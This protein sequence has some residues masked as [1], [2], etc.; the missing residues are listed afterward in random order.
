MRL[1]A[2]PQLRERLLP[3]FLQA[4][5]VLQRV[6]AIGVRPQGTLVYVGMHRGDGFERL[7]RRF[8]RSIGI[9]ANPE[10]F[11]ALQR[12]YR[13][14][15]Y[16]A[17]YNVAA[18]AEAG[19]ARF[20]ISS[21]DGKSSSLGEF[22]ADWTQRKTGQVRMD[23]SIRVPCVNLYEFLQEQG[24]RHIDYYLSDI[25]GMDLTVLKTLRPLI[26]QRAIG[27]IQCEV[28]KDA[29]GNVYAGLET[30]GQSGFEELLGKHYELAGTGWGQVREG[31][32]DGTP[33]DWWEMDCLWV[34]RTAGALGG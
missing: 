15:P 12:R 33:E 19:H 14:Y 21:N 32:F 17:L 22:R 30:N 20:N 18:A 13:R 7:F 10:L 2:G 27:R 24:I 31:R 1:T 29:Y 9:E 25:Q 28:A 16:V 11:R 3:L 6:R 8:E 34:R 4:H 5:S 26:E 23:G